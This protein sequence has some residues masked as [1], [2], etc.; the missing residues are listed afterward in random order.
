MPIL[1]A[2]PSGRFRILQVTDFHDDADPGLAEE[3][4][5]NVETL[6]RLHH[7]DFLAI[8]GDIW[9][10][11]DKEGIAASLMNAA[12][13][14][15]ANCGVPWVFTWGNHDYVDDLAK[16]QQQ[17]ASTPGARMDTGDGLGSCRVAIHANGASAWDLFFIN[18]GLEWEP[19]V[20]LHW[21]MEESERL[22]N[23][24]G[25]IVPAVAFYHIPLRQY[26]DARLS[27]EFTG[28]AGE[29]VLCWGDDGSI[30]DRFAE[31][32]NIRLGLC[33]HSHRNDFRTEYKGI[34]LAYGRS[35]GIGGYGPEMKKGGTLITLD[36][37][38]AAFD[39][40]T[41]FPDGALWRHG[42]AKN[43]RDD[44]G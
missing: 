25:R 37:N 18:S 44:P 20:D 30:A 12:L 2:P 14:R 24:R 34:T 33:G 35:T 40:I 16:R 32:E 7:P 27:D 38:A 42:D 22:K 23:D 8:T 4:W 28:I 36:C 9:C 17:I 26:E 19:S 6:I 10:A 5:G 13:D 21:F 1:A 41:V 43:E 29:E 3:T 39:L 11:D 31:M 15:F